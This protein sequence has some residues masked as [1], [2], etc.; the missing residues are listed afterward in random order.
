ML[1]SDELLELHTRDAVVL[2][3]RAWTGTPYRHQSR[4]LGRGVDCVGLIIAAGL[5]AGVMEW[6]EEDFAPWRGYGRLP[7]PSKMREGL[8]KFLREIPPEQGPMIGDV[9][10]FRWREGLPM[11]LG[12]LAAH[13]RP[14]AGLPPRLTIIHATQNVGKVVEHAFAGEWPERVESWWSYPALARGG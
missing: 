13:A 7:N 1:K 5:D 4:V 2:A 9:A 12:I 6:T 14:E 8:E 3:A 10:W 11:H